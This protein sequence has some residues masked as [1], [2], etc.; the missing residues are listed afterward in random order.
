VS[1]PP[2]LDRFRRGG[3][4][5]V[6]PAVLASP[7]LRPVMLAFLL[8]NAVEYATWV[9][10]LLYAYGA[11]GP[12]S[13]G[14]VG[15]AQLVPSAIF[16]PVA[17]T[18]A[19][20]YPRERVLPAGYLIQAAAMALTAAGMVLGAP[21]L[22]VYAAAAVAA[23]VL[24]L[25]RPTQG[26]LLPT[27]ARTPDEL[28]AANGLAGSVE[29]VGL[30]VGPLAA[31]AILVV[32]ATG[33]VFAAG[34]A[35]AAVAALLVARLP[36]PDG[37][38]TPMPE[39]DHDPEGAAGHEH[40]EHHAHEAEDTLEGESAGRRLVRGLG[41]LSGHPDAGLVV[42]IL[43][44][45][46]IVIGAMD[47]LYVLL[48]LDVLGTGEPGAGIL[49]AAMGL[50]TIAG[51]AATFALVGRRRLAPVIAGGAV[52][53]GAA[54]VVL[55]GV[56]TAW[57]AAALFAVTGMG[58][59]VIDVA[60][61]TMLQR[62]AQDRVLVRLLG[63]LEGMG[64][65]GLAVG[66][67]LVAA[68]TGFVSVQAAVVVSGLVVPVAVG[69]AWV[70]LRAIDA[71]ADVPVHELALLRVNPILSP[72]PAPQLEAVA[73][74]CRWLTLEVGEVLIRE[75]DRGDRYYVLASGSV[76]IT[77]GGRFLRD[78][79]RPG[80]GLGEIALLRDVPRTATA[81]AT[82]SVVALSLD[83]AEFLEAV[84]GHEQARASGI[85]VADERAATGPD[86]EGEP[87]E[88]AGGAA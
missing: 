74:R 75:G 1:P 79:V 42:G 16:A 86:E 81:S 46:M 63:A 6:V 21:P 12:A 67:I 27:L 8:F 54:L 9:A 60:G 82:S 80:D 45:R 3:T 35:G 83:R 5:R 77:Q 49:N 73:R 2:R 28:T 56:G 58:L 10:I 53:V 84:T 76:R 40:H 38:A 20:R 31:A 41:T 4:S 85:R 66:S 43:S 11:T 23:S 32:A 48:A 34:A 70:R 59:A 7:A 50:G 62:V 44:V 72:L 39:H 51:G 14:V 13:V 57:L 68:V 36:I 78:L 69:L 64:M 19:D 29:G 30:L 65:A 26:A 24:T 55:A 18:L 25:T 37:D 61:R 71:R 22:A 17:A 88:D 87:A 15:L 52:A 33:A 47:V